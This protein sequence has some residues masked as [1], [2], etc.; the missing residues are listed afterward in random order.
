MQKTCIKE[1]MVATLGVEPQ[2]VT[3]ALDQLLDSKYH[4]GEVTVIY[5][6]DPQVLEA[7]DSIKQEFAVNTYPGISLRPVVVTS[8]TGPVADFYDQEDLKALI[9]TLYSEVRRVRKSGARLHFCLAGGRKVMSILGMVVSQLLFGPEDK[10][11]YLITEGWQPGV[12]RKLHTTVKDKVWLLQVPVLRWNEAG[13]LVQTVAELN[14]PAEAVVWYERLTRK[15]QHKRKAEFIKHWLTPAER[16]VAHQACL[17]LNNAAIAE[18][19]SKKEQT[20]ANQ[21]GEVYEKLQEWLDYPST[22]VDRSILIAEFAP[23][24]ALMEEGNY[25][26]RIRK[27]N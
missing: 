11:W 19:L 16:Q 6:H 18:A 13:T 23:Y 2:V 12:E 10:A 9:H 5:T 26:D 20:V 17:G 4:I 8:D 24:F 14:N 27:Y 25:E 3:I 22:K 1:T 7:L 15:A 21:L